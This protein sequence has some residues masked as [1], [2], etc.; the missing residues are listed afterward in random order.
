M[1]EGFLREFPNARP[2]VENVYLS[3]I[4]YLPK[5][6]PADECQRIIAL[7]DAEQKLE[8]QIGRGQDTQIRDSKVCYIKVGDE[9]QWIYEK[10]EEKQREAYYKELWTMLRL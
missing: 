5:H 3:L 2:M 1:S 7:A 10:L 9:S 4:A 6:F 8:G